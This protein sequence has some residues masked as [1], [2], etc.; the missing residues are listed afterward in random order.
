MVARKI[1]SPKTS[2]GAR[3]IEQTCSD[4]EVFVFDIEGTLVDAMMRDG[5][6]CPHGCVPMHEYGSDVA[7]EFE[8]SRQDQ[9]PTEVAARFLADQH[10]P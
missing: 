1:T 10:L 7:A 9:D 2:R 6:N 4:A 3:S 8:I 5:L